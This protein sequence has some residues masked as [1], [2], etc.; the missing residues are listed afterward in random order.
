MPSTETI[1]SRIRDFIDKAS[2][3]VGRLTLWRVGEADP[4]HTWDRGALDAGHIA[5][6]ALD[7]ASV[8][9]GTQEFELRSSNSWVPTF[10]F[11]VVGE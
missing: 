8:W 5:L 10:R 3:P 6:Y 11:E 1:S 9:E 4:L 2:A 7:Y